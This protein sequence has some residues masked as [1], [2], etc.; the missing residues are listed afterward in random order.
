[1][2]LNTPNQEWQWDAASTTV[3]LHSIN[4]ARSC[5]VLGSTRCPSFRPIMSTA[6][7]DVA[8]TATPSTEALDRRSLGP[9]EPALCRVLASHHG[10][11]VAQVARRTGW[12]AKVIRRAV[13]NKYAHPDTVAEDDG[14][15]KEVPELTAI[16]DHMLQ[17]RDDAG[18]YLKPPPQKKR[19][20][21]HA[22]SKASASPTNASASTALSQR[23]S[24]NLTN[25]FLDEFVREAAL[26]P[27][28]YAMFLEVGYDEEGLRRMAQLDAERIEEVAQSTF[29][30]KLSQ[31][32]RALFVAA[33]R[34][35]A[36]PV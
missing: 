3:V 26:H 15:V 12:S 11:L 16:V 10:F 1:M 29:R 17:T 20:V 22:A 28:W 4:G 36:I 23:R 30:E 19:T 33:V 5:L 6:T 9:V 21:V 2:K 27:K 8:L 35:L 34:H 7:A 31:M 32:D 25:K 13:Q 18:N 24:L 14:R